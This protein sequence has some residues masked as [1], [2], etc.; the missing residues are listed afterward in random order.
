MLIAK[1]HIVSVLPFVFPVCGI[2]YDEI[3]KSMQKVYV[4][5]IQAFVLTVISYL[6][7]L[8]VVNFVIAF[9]FQY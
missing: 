7:K 4:R 2:N 9:L 8:S 3:F 6:Y 1:Q 5:L